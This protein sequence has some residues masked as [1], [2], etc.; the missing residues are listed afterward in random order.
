MKSTTPNATHTNSNGQRILEMLAGLY[1]NAAIALFYTSPWELLVAVMLSAQCTDKKVNEV[2]PSLFRQFPTVQSFASAN[3]RTLERQIFPTGFYHMKASHI[4]QTAEIILNNYHGTV[5]KTL[6]DLT[7]LPGVG[8]KTA[9]IVLANAYG[10]ATGIPVDTHVSRITQ[11]LRLVDIHTIGAGSPVWITRKNQR[12]LDYY[13]QPNTDRI[14]AQLCTRIPISQWNKISYQIIE[15]GRTLC[16]AV[17]PA[18][19]SCPLAHLCPASR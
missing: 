1:P 17:G 7:A 12:A 4:Q 10:I 5:P 2:T 3:I 15:H 8:R 6:T 14:E 11:R 19:S 13:R 16:R 18:C 9:H